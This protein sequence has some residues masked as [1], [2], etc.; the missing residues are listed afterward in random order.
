MIMS[1]VKYLHFLRPYLHE[2]RPSDK[3]AYA[4]FF[5]VA[6]RISSRDS[7]CK[8]GAVYYST[9]RSSAL[10][11]DV[12]QNNVSTTAPR[13][14]TV[15][16][17]AQKLKEYNALQWPR[18]AISSSQ[19][20]IGRFLEDYKDEYSTPGT[21]EVTIE[22]RIMSIRRVGSKLA[23]IHIMGGY[24]EL[25]VMVNLGKLATPQLTLEVLK[26]ALHPLRRGDIISIKG[27]AIR[28][29][30][31][32]LSLGA[33]EM[34][35]ML[36][37]SLASLPDSITNEKTIA[38]NRPL[39]LL[40]HKSALETSRLRSHIIRR[41]RDFFHENEFIEVQT[42]ILAD[43]AGGATARPFLTSSIEFP[44]KELALRIAP[45]LWL[46]R[47]VVGGHD[48]IFEVGPSFRNEGLDGTHNPEFNMCEFYWAYS[49]LTEL[50]SFTEDM[51]RQL[52][53]DVE[54]F[55]RSEC[56]VLQ[57]PETKLPNGR[58]KQVEFIPALQDKL[59]FE[60]P[61]LTEPDALEILIKLLQVNG[62]PVTWVPG[63]A[64]PKLLDHLAA[65]FLEPLSIEQPLFIVHHPACM[66][67]LSKSFTDA[68]TGQ[69]VSA[70]AELFMGGSEIANMYEEENN[71]FEQRRKFELQL[72]TRDNS[73][74]DRDEIPA[75]VDENYIQ[76][77][78]QGLPPTGGWGCGVDRL[79][80]LL[81]GVHRISDT[82]SFGSLKNVVSLSQAGKSS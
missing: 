24:Q 62:H 73:T 57:S 43:Y 18:M 26:N 65:T 39:N 36:S 21:K 77:L 46:K 71:P 70:R 35:Q 16:G 61:D 54:Q 7:Q 17:R 25:Q 32:E 37:P 48:R 15:D 47:L 68:A 63:V 44:E 33:T 9:K 19:S 50:I 2:A 6:S 64:L 40:V 12:P 27:R 75:D 10:Q 31:G 30:T 13:A 14:V 49:N 58:W 34:P 80:M 82:L 60:F 20:R 28:T 5:S 1:S 59:G 79:V 29:N 4:R 38:L 66:S 11:S 3:A 42:P 69:V 55:V 8:A 22:G 74:A 78:E 56:K 76:A 53:E 81:S 67:P 45:E 51:L 72:Q 23:F 52:V 41:M